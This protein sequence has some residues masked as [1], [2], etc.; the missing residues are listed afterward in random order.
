MSTTSFHPTRLPS[1][2]TTHPPSHRLC[3]L[4]LVTC[5]R[6]SRP[7]PTCPNQRKDPLNLRPRCLAAA[8]PGSASENPSAAATLSMRTRMKMRMRRSCRS[9]RK[10]SRTKMRWREVSEAGYIYR[11]A[12]H[13]RWTYWVR[14]T[15]ERVKYNLTSD[16]GIKLILF[17]SPFI[18]PNRWIFLPPA[19]SAA[20]VEP[21]PY[22]LGPCSPPGSREALTPLAVRP[23]SAGHPG[24]E[25]REREGQPGLRQHLFLTDPPA[26]PVQT[27]RLLYV[28]FILRLRGRGLLP[29][30][31]HTS[32][33]AA[34]K[35]ATRGGQR[36]GGRRGE[37]VAERLG[38]ERQHTAEESSK[39]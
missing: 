32:A 18:F 38:T 9:A 17:S 12:S 10:T 24:L 2:P 4:S 33:P 34:P 37:G 23:T 14:T 30:T 16:L 1:R 15:F 20:W 22:P 25:S 29:G 28:L 39:S 36:Q 3:P 5:C 21:L 19:E 31:A 26:G 27:R 7:H 13:R 6:R 8:Q 11:K 35:A